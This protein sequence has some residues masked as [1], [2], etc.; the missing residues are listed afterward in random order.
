[1]SN[2]EIKL[3]LENQSLKF[4]FALRNLDLNEVFFSTPDNLAQENR[5]LH[6]L[7]EWVQK[8]TMYRNR[9]MME[10]DGYIYPPID[11]DISP[12]EDWFRFERWVKG[13]PLR[14]ILIDML[15]ANYIP[16]N[17]THLTDIEILQELEILAKY[18]AEVYVLFQFNEDVPPR[19]AY[20]HL[21]EV[22]EDEFEIMKEGYWILDGC[23]SDCPSC[24]QRPWCETG[25]TTCWP[26]D[27]E[28]GE[29]YLIEEIKDY[30]SPSSVSLDILQMCQALEDQA[31][32][33]FET[34]QDEWDIPLGHT[35][36]DDDTILF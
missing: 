29:I 14:Q 35:F 24:F 34:D 12:E 15:P 19:L 10:M 13:E 5:A 3:F 17:P 25:C 16:K 22:L 1:M 2:E 27:E 8:Y 28:A 20:N 36:D 32:A 11:P 30:A 33:A 26:E 21:L 18:L 31:L 23:T 9:Q 4:E 7:L 6:N